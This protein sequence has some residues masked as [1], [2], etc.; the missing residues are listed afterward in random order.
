VDLFPK[1]YASSNAL[2]RNPLSGPVFNCQVQENPMLPRV[3]RRRWLQL[4]GGALVSAGSAAG[5]HFSRQKK[6]RLGMIGAGGRAESHASA[7]RITKLFRTRGDIMAVCDVDRSRAEELCA[8]YAKSAEIMQ[9]CRHLLARDDIDAVFIATPDHWHAPLSIEALRAG[10][11]VYCEK[12]MTLT[13]AEGQQ[14]I[15]AVQASDR[16]FLIGTQCR[17][18]PLFQRACELVRNGRL[19][20]LNRISITVPDNRVGGPFIGQTTPTSLDWDA[21]LGP[22]PAA[23]YCRERCRAWRWWYEYSGGSMTD[24]GSHQIDIAHWAMDLDE[25]GPIEVSTEGVLP[26]INNGFNTPE[27]YSVEFKYAN[28]VAIHL[29]TN[30]NSNAI[31]FEG[32]RG[33]IRVSR[34]HLT[35]KPVEDLAS[36]PLPPDSIRLGH[37]HFYP[38][39]PQLM[40][41]QHF[42]DCV[43]N[44]ERPISNVV[45]QHRSV[46]ACHLANIALRLQRSLKWDPVAE[47]IVNDPQAAAMLARK[48]RRV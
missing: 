31:L 39:N 9:D 34:N 1:K 29:E 11:H 27:N 47:T 13:V 25:S 4:S 5:W 10:K 6:I 38:G 18:D 20:K 3:S 17:S 24:W 40:H 19:G 23:D 12:P 21:W 46:T 7:L 41:I 22:A 26:S 2:E 44:G 28:G 43:T 33:R 16:T 45:T 42:F 8:K 30:P 15:K 36:D 14:L 48:A 37:P 32:E 35:G